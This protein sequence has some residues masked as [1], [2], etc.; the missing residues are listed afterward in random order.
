MQAR[1]FYTELGIDTIPLRPDDNTGNENG[2]KPL[3]AEW[4]IQ[5]PR[6]LWKSAP[7]NANVGLRGGGEIGAAFLDCDDKNKAGTFENVTRFLHG[8]GVTEYPLIQTAS[9][10][11]RHIYLTVT[12]APRGNACDLAES[13]GKGE[14]RY[15]AGA[16]VCAAPSVVDGRYYSVLSGNF[17]QIP[18]VSYTDLHPIL[19][20]VKDFAPS[21][22]IPRNALSILNGD[23]EAIAK[24]KS[25][26]EAEQSLLLCLANVG[27]TFADVVHLFNNH[28]CAGKYAELRAA[29]AKNAE[30]WLSHSFAEAQRISQ[31][32]SKQRE[33]I[34]QAVAWA[35][36]RAWPG[37][38]GASE[39]AVFLA[40]MKIAYKAGTTR[41]WAADKRTLAE[42]A[43]VSD[44]SK[45][46][47]RLLIAGIL[48]LEKRFTVDRANKY[49]LSTTL[50]LPKYSNCVEVVTLCKDAFRNSNQLNRQKERMAFGQIGRQ[51]WEVLR[52]APMMAEDLADSTGRDR[53]TVE[54][55]LERM[56][57]LTNQMTGEI[58]PMVERTFTA[59]G[60]IWRALSVDLDSVALA[61]GTHGKGTEQRLKHIK[62]RRIH[63]R[64][65]MLTNKCAQ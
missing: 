51:L 21:P 32:D 36:E 63:E 18:N 40:H 57:T 30:R 14:F 53:R 33:T 41:G 26:S 9:G 62:E 61:I 29:N 58:L 59:E 35:N 10:V 4:Q 55:Y 7:Q 27:F 11:G 42:S 56:R 1:D 46:N 25:R 39:Q 44:A 48:K 2:K 31:K 34:R 49:S 5:S 45:I 52:S 54:K 8:L 60:E 24:F 50:P 43:G 23:V 22:K 28:P 38:G 64:Q 3:Y 65:L 20:E 47:K 12:D 19:G 15:G 17:D 13:T 6:R 16:Y 37:K